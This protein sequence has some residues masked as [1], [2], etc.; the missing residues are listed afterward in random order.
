MAEYI[1]R[2]AAIKAVEKADYTAISSDADDCKADYLREIIESVPAADVVP[3]VHGEWLLRHEGHGHYWECSVCHKNP[4]IYVT[5][6][7]NYCPNCGAKMDGG[8]D[9]D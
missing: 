8:T 9:N 6:D 3:V 5:K 2:E 4:C 7:T 1:N